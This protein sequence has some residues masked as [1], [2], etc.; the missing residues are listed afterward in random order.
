MGLS[1]VAVD[2]KQTECGVRQAAHSVYVIVAPFVYLKL[3]RA[4][5]AISTPFLTVRTV[6]DCPTLS[7]HAQLACSPSCPAS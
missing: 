4:P 2:S 3:G 6:Y 7:D 5:Q 1:A